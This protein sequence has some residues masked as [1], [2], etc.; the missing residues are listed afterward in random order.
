MLS[1]RRSKTRRR[2]VRRSRGV[3]SRPVGVKYI[4]GKDP[5]Q[6][7][8]KRQKELEKRQKELEWRQQEY[9]EILPNYGS[10]AKQFGF[11]FNNPN[12]NRRDTVTVA[13]GTG[14]PNTS[15]EFSYNSFSDYRR[16]LVTTLDQ[17]GMLP[18]EEL[19]NRKNGYG[20]RFSWEEEPV[21]ISHPLSSYEISKIDD[22]RRADEK[23]GYSVPQN[24]WL[25]RNLHDEP[26]Q[27][28]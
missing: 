17:K 2:S 11:H 5:R 3:K 28:P 15:K 12:L 6:E 20:E 18:L 19:L 7:L 9:I 21:Q 27:H 1:K 4:V 8:E 22:Q 16:Q 26:E 10:L 13:H 24:K 25:G 23:K 14:K